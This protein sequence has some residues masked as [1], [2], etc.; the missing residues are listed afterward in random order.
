MA[1]S[2]LRPD[3]SAK[4]W[5]GDRNVQY[6]HEAGTIGAIDTIDTIEMSAPI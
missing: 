3:F 5:P 4:A 6:V 1:E 2:G